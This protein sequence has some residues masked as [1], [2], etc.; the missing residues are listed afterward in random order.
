V[1]YGSPPPHRIH[2]VVARFWPPILPIDIVDHA[3]Q[4]DMISRKEP[5]LSLFALRLVCFERGTGP[6]AF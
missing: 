4:D 1:A 2:A 6:C 3:F 5:R